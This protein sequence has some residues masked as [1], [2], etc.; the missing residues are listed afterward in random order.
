M[1]AENSPASDPN[2]GGPNRGAHNHL[3]SKPKLWPQDLILGLLP[4]LLV[5]QALI[6]YFYLPLGL[7]GVADFRQLYTG[8]YMIRTGHASE[9]YDYDAQMRFQAQL[10]PEA[11]LV[12]LLITH[13]AFEELLFV[14]LSVLSYRTAFWTFFVVNLALLAA[15]LRL[16][17]PYLR[18]LTERWPLFPI[19]ICAVFFPISRT[20]L[21]GQD[22]IL[23]LALLSGAFVLL[24]HHQFT[25][26]GALVGCGVFRFQIVIPI[27]LLYLLWKRWRFV[28]GFG[29]TSSAAALLSLW[30]VGI[31]GARSY[32]NYMLNLSTRMATQAD[33]EHF[34]N[35]PMG[36]LNLRG[37]ISR[38]L[39]NRAPHLWIEVA[40]FAASAL[41]VLLALRLKPSLPSAIITASL[42]SYHFIAHDATIWIIPILL[43]LGG[44]SVGEALLAVGMLIGPFTAIFIFEGIESH[45]YL[46]AVPVVGLFLLKTVRATRRPRIG[47]EYVS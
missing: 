40:I 17:W 20:L 7:H 37:L 43:A 41:T 38:V 18:D 3:L 25:L 22:S 35:S 47:R 19:A 8:G 33:M 39:W 11:A 14:P 42:V 10:V 12:R 1:A 29:V 9:L 5:I 16:L 46:G 4:L 2:R 30:I 26:A 6:W 27:A 36:M 24:Q 23:L 44:T 31:H 45:A 15:S 28:I 13:P 34:A 21:Q 32:V